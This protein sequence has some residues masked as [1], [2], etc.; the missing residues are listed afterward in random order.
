MKAENCTEKSNKLLRWVKYSQEHVFSWKE[1]SGILFKNNINS[2]HLYTVFTVFLLL[3]EGNRVSESLASRTFFSAKSYSFS[4]GS[5]HLKNLSSHPLSSRF[6]PLYSR[7]PAPCPPPLTC[8][9]SQFNF[10]RK[11]KYYPNLTS[12][13]ISWVDLL[14]TKTR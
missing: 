3:M 13:W 7:A 12:F 6:P 11:P 1:K 14:N 9:E 10:A 5:R 8:Q 4:T 2:G